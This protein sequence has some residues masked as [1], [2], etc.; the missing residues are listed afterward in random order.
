MKIGLDAIC[1]SGMSGGFNRY[2]QQVLD[3]LASGSHRHTFFL[4]LNTGAAGMQLP[5]DRRFETRRISTP[6]RLQYFWNQLWPPIWAMSRQ[7]DVW[8]AVLAP[9]PQVCTVSTIVTVHDLSFEHFP[10]MYSPAA[11]WYWR[12][13]LPSSLKRATVVLADSEYTRTDVLELYSIPP[14]KVRVLYPCISIDDTAGDTQTTA[15][16]YHL[17]AE[18]FLYVGSMHPRKNLPTLVKAFALL[19]ARTGIPHKLVLVGPGGWGASEV[20]REIA[21]SSYRQDIIRLGAVPSAHLP[22]I[23]RRASAF[24][25]PSL[26]EGFGYPPLEAMGYGVP[27]IVSNASCL[28]EVVGN[29]GLTVDPKSEEDLAEAMGAIVTSSGLAERLRR[30]GLERVKRFSAQTMLDGLLAAY[31]AVKTIR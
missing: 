13:Y 8:H 31:E 16:H 2:L 6:P 11:L 10:E 1:L 18:Y 7:M 4:M 3:A 22:A 9:P 12:H 27:A 25:Y 21:T 15:T 30:L 29:A 23:F 14:D 24:V 17:P 26:Y 5:A 19:K 28:P 20:E